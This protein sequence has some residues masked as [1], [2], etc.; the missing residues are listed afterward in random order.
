MIGRGR[1]SQPEPDTN[2]RQFSGGWHSGDA[3][4]TSRLTDHTPRPDEDPRPHRRDG[5]GRQ[6]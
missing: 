3:S 5:I 6:D 4:D 2:S 1:R